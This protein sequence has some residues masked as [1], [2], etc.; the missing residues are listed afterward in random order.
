VLSKIIGG[1]IEMIDKRFGRYE[2]LS[3]IGRGRMATVYLAQDTQVQRRV[4]IKIF[5]SEFINN[6]VIKTRLLREAALIS[7]LEHSAI[8]PIYDFGELNNQVFVAMRYMSGGSLEGLLASGTFSV[9]ETEGVVNR[10]ASACDFAHHRRVIHGSL[11]P[12][13]VLFDQ[14]GNAFVADFGFARL[15]LESGLLWQNMSGKYAAYLAPEQLQNRVL[16]STESDIYALGILIFKMLTGF[17]PSE[18][19]SLAGQ[20]VQPDTSVIPNVR[21][22]RPDLPS[23]VE[24]VVEKATQ[25]QPTA[26][27]VSAGALA[28][29]FTSALERANKERPIA[30]TGDAPTRKAANE[31]AIAVAVAPVVAGAVSGVAIAGA[32]SASQS[33]LL[34][35]LQAVLLG[36]FALGLLLA[37]LFLVFGQLFVPTVTPTPIPLSP[38]A[39][40]V[41]FTATPSAIP[42]ITATNI[43]GALTGRIPTSTAKVSET[44]TGVVTS[45]VATRNASPESSTTLTLL[46]ETVTVNAIGSTTASANSSATT[47]VAN[48][49]TATQSTNTPTSTWTATLTTQPTATA[50]PPTAVPSDTPPPTQTPFPTNTPIPPSI[51]PLPSPTDIPIPPTDIP[52]NPP[53]ATVALNS[54]NAFDDPTR[55]S[56]AQQV[57]S[58]I[59]NFRAQNGRAGLQLANV[60]VNTAQLRSNDLSDRNYFGHRDPS[61]GAIMITNYLSTQIFG[62]L[63]ETL[64]VSGY[65]ADPTDVANTVVN[66]WR[67]SG[68]YSQ[69]LLD[70]R[71]NYIGLGITLDTSC[72]LPEADSQGRCWL[73]SAI[74]T[75]NSGN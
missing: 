58:G 33:V 18:A 70:A 41:I 15:G 36:V 32:G 37:G 54:D 39:Q 52:T 22:I 10:L 16:F 61:T 8:V 35:N 26:R 3:E 57:L 66:E 29:D 67:T 1:I 60:L 30:K 17:L 55:S 5:H 20:S 68:S 53:V 40:V 48:S 43:S 45:D 64:F 31:E 47:T 12:N 24:V 72:T 13:N 63:A 50:L 51:T 19:H 4:A 73:I 11:S 69:Y 14:Q 46:P 9:V 25:Y 2:L 6:G 62:T 23:G 28:A 38:T 42:P 65:N 56:I 75:Q 7:S 34:K 71:H 49:S 27:Y 21:A 59:N 74:Y 44:A